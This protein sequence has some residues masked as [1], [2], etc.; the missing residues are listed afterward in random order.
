M[1]SMPITE[2]GKV[3]GNLAGEHYTIIHSIDFLLQG[4]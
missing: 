3:K 1:A 2:L 4:F